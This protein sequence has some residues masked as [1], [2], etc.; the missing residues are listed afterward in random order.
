[1]LAGGIAVA[2]LVA[3]LTF[4]SSLHGLLDSPDLYGWNWDEAILDQ[5]GYGNLAIAGAHDSLDGNPQVAAWSGGYFGADSI[6][7]LN[8][9]LLGMEPKSAVAPPL[10]TG[11]MIAADDE[12]VL[13]PATADALGKS[14]GDD[15]RIGVGGAGATLHVVGI[16]TFPTIGITHGAH[17]SLGVGALVA[18]PLVPGFDRQ[19]TGD[20]PPRSGPGPAGPPVIFVRHATGADVGA[21]HAAVVAAASSIGQYPG[22][23]TVLGSQ[24]PAEVVN[25]DDVGGAPALLASTLGG[26]AVVSLSIALA[27]SVRRRRRELA[28]LRSLGFTQRQV[29]ATVAWQST[30]T[31]TVGLLVGAPIGIAVGRLLWAAFADQLDVVSRPVVPI[32]Q[33]IL[34]VALALVLAAVAAAIPAGMAQRIRTA[35][36]L[37]GE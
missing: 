23:A 6:D 17:T 25:T 28:L 1:M 24:R 21:A 2:T 3:A 37:A 22:S 16:A 33:L 27:A 8:V 30:A 4:G 20:G 12:V 36:V 26:A 19:A 14:T 13:G 31:M 34:I 11:R 7:G 35:A 18:P 29:A 10:L 5:D 32:V 9:A 15:V